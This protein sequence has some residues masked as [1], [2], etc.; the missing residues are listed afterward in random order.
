M[1]TFRLLLQTAVVAILSTS[2]SNAAVVI[3]WDSEIDA[4]TYSKLI[5]D[6][7]GADGITI[8]TS[9]ANI[10]NWT[11]TGSTVAAGNIRSDNHTSPTSGNFVSRFEGGSR[12]YS[13]VLDIAAGQ[14]YTF[15]QIS[16]DV[17]GATNGASTGRSASFSITTGSGLQGIEF[18]IGDSFVGTQ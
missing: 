4:S 10:N 14:A 16:F 12:T 17:R 15:D 3:N 9:A 11:V 2:F 6:P 7:I 18:K 13:I 8:N 5:E 1:N